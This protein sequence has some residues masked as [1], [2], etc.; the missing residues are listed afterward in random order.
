MF[1][2]AKRRENSL[3]LPVLPLARTI[4]SN[5]GFSLMGFGLLH[6]SHLC[7]C[8]VAD[9]KGKAA[10]LGKNGG[11]GKQKGGNGKLFAV[12]AQKISAQQNQYDKHQGKQGGQEQIGFLSSHGSLG[13]GG[14]MF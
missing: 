13:E 6:T 3:S 8:F 1:K 4:F 10:D 5:Y 2:S 9:V 14:K 12:N 11:K 7:A